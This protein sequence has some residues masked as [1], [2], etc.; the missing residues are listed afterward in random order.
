MSQTVH[1][2]WPDSGYVLAPSALGVRS[3]MAV[4]EWV[5]VMVILLMVMMMVMVL[6]M[7]MVLVM[8]VI[9]LVIVVADNAAVHP[10]H[11]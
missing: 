7:V 1:H 3:C 6:L 8:A 11:P 4:M 2:I 9:L 10:S 5:M